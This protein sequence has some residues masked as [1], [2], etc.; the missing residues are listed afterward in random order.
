MT[1]LSYD[2]RAQCRPIVSA[3]GQLV[4]AKKNNFAL[5]FVRNCEH[6]QPQLRPEYFWSKLQKSACQIHAIEFSA[7]GTT[8]GNCATQLEQPEWH[9][10]TTTEVENVDL[11][12]L[13]SARRALAFP[14]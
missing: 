6:E 3:I 10:Q 11:A 2:Y 13:A 14:G 8:S 9:F 7:I 12:W 4:E 5:A 1:S